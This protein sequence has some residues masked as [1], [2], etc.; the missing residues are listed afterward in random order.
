MWDSSD[1]VIYLDIYCHPHT[2]REGEG[3]DLSSWLGDKTATHH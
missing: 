3:C 2:L 1:F